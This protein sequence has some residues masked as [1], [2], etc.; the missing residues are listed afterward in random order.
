MKNI[1]QNQE[2]T[3]VKGTVCGITDFGAFVKLPDDKEG[4]IH[5]SEISPS[6]VKNVADFL[7]VGQVISVKVLG[8]NK[9]GK[10]DLSIKQINPSFQPLKPEER[11]QQK[12]ARKEV[13]PEDFYPKT[14]QAPTLRSLED[15]IGHFIKRSDEKLLDIRKN[16]QAKQGFPKRKKN[17]I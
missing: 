7:K 15:K 1:N 5:I 10:L 16:V 9:R 14:K 11:N 17:K 12:A 2:G 8:V 4:L 6:F 3:I 13:K